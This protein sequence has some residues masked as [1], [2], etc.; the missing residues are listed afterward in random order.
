MKNDN[1]NGGWLFMYGVI[2]VSS[3][4]ALIVMVAT[5]DITDLASFAW[6]ILFAI[7]AIGTFSIYKAWRIT[8]KRP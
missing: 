1:D 8:H 4:T 3:F 7:F 5:C 6:D 2:A